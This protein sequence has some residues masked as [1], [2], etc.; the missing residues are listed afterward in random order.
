MDK[1]G[2]TKHISSPEL[3]SRLLKHRLLKVHV[4]FYIPGMETNMYLP[5]IF[6]GEVHSECHLVLWEA[7]TAYAF[8]DA[9]DDY[10]K[11][12]GEL[13]KPK[14][15]VYSIT[16]T[17][18]FWETIYLDK[19]ELVAVDHPDSV[20]IFV[21]EQF[22][23]PPFPGYHSFQVKEKAFSCFCNRFKG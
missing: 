9:S 23:P 22:S 16:V 18:E 20:E 15:G 7:T 4:R 2:S 11:I 13:L 5:R 10:L 12:P 1:R 19:V 3:T 6:C 21:P 8:P 17:S 14:D